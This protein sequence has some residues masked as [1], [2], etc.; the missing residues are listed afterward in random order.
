[1]TGN[2]D[3]CMALLLLL[4]LLLMMM[5]IIIIIIMCF[6]SS[7]HSSPSVERIGEG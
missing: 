3:N 5:M 6:I 4:L 2:R 1:M 7:L